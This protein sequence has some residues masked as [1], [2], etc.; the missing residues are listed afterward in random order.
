MADNNFC[1]DIGEK[2]TKVS[3]AK[4]VDD[5]L[6]INALGKIDTGTSFYISDLEK[7]A[8]EHALEIKKLVNSLKIT[9]KNVNVVVPGSFTYS[10]ILV[11]PQLNEKELVSAIKYQ[12]DQFIP[13]PIEETNIDL[14][15]IEELKTEKKLLILI[16]AAPKKLIEKIQTTIEYAGFIPESIENE[17]SASSRLISQFNKKF[18]LPDQGGVMV[19]NFGLNSTTLAYFDPISSNIKESHNFSVGYHL[20]L[21]EISVNADTDE[22]KSLEILRVFDNKS[23]S[24]Y[25][26]EKITGPLIREFTS[27]V[28]RFV[29]DKKISVIYIFNQIFL[30]PALCSFVTQTVGIPTK[31]LDPYPFIIKT[32]TADAAKFELSLYA[33]SFGGNLR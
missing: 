10:Q 22:K 15:I 8:E 33:S 25:P 5:T 11:M 32:P 9:K 17:L 24:T 28:K 12:A 23:N 20:F 19:A 4:K 21:K 13:M 18:F 30:F 27:E 29:A 16:V 7:S 1:I 6:Q 2:Y 14:E 26:V 3:D 31:I